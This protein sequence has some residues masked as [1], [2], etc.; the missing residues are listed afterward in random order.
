MKNIAS[1]VLAVAATCASDRLY[2][3]VGCVDEDVTHWRSDQYSAGG[4]AISRI[5]AD[6]TMWRD[7]FLSNKEA[8]LEMLSASEDLTLQ[9]AIRWDKGDRCVRPMPRP[10]HPPPDCEEGRDD[11]LPISA[12]HD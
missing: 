11:A 10:R 9:R 5:A 7:V 1:L 12:T 2:T 4:F 8:V 6:P 3:I